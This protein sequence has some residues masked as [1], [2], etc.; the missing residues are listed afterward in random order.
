MVGPLV[1]GVLRSIAGRDRPVWRLLRS[2]ALRF[3][4]FHDPLDCLIYALLVSLPRVRFLQIGANDGRTGDRLWSFRRYPSWSGVLVEPQ[5]AAFHR[6]AMNYRRWP[7]RFDLV[8]VAV[9][10][11]P[12]VRPFYHLAEGEEIPG[13]FDQL[14]SLDEALVDRH[15]RRLSLPDALPIEVTEIRCVT[16]ADL[17]DHSGV[18][19]VVAI[20]AEGSD[21]AIVAQLDLAADRPE[22]LA[23]E[24]IHL[25]GE[26][27]A[28][29]TGGLEA[30]GYATLSAGPD[31]VAVA[32]EGLQRLPRLAEAWAVILAAGGRV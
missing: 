12:G 8:N 27:R 28:A 16:L 18:V 10:A 24:H 3:R 14:G 26:N 19:N 11:T 22:V 4:V 21:A 32:R 6:L 31:T 9:A 25:T 5:E 20:D 30:S 13:H 23:Y 7:G 15:R 2:P 17:L 29:T 1:R